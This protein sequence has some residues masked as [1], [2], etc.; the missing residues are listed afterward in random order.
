M[1]TAVLALVALLALSAR[2]SIATALVCLFLVV[3]TT[4]TVNAI[5]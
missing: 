4:D 2:L 5:I 3:A 1:A